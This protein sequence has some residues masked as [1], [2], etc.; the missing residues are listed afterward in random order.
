MEFESFFRVGDTVTLHLEIRIEER[1]NTPLRVGKD[2]NLTKSLFVFFI[3]KTIYLKDSISNIQ[4]NL[5]LN[6]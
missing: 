6:N 5:I 2:N 1:H 3:N 4:I